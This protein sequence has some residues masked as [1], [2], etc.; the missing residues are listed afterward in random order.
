MKHDF[1]YERVSKIQ[2]KGQRNDAI[3]QTCWLV[4]DPWIPLTPTHMVWH[5][6]IHAY[7]LI[8]NTKLAGCGDTHL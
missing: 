4:F 3:G 7:T 8:R 6:C 1:N 5:I 2:R